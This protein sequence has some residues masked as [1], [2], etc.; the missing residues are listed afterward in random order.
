MACSRGTLRCTS[1]PLARSRP[2][3]A[4]SQGD[5]FAKSRWE[6]L[7]ALQAQKHWR[8]A[9]SSWWIAR[10][11]ADRSG[12]GH[13]RVCKN[14]WRT[15]EGDVVARKFGDNNA[16]RTLSRKRSKSEQG[17]RCHPLPAETV[18]CAK[19]YV[20]RANAFG[21][22]VH[23]VPPIWILRMDPPGTWPNTV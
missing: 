15:P 11:Y 21:L 3:S 2:C 12:G 23:R 7:Y 13:C 10:S 19:S 9:H 16:A 6:E 22:V 14:R 20:Q 8:A 18:G 1:V 17:E 5:P 4:M